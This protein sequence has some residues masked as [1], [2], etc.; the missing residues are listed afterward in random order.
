[1]PSSLSDVGRARRYMYVILLF[2]ILLAYEFVMNLDKGDVEHE[3]LWKHKDAQT[4]QGL[5][6]GSVLVVGIYFMSLLECAR[7]L[8]N[9]VGLRRGKSPHSTGGRDRPAEYPRRGRGVAATRLRRNSHVA[10]SPRL[11]VAGYPRLGV[12]ATRLRGISTSRCR[13]GSS[14]RNIRVAESASQ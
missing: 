11:A 8:L 5:Y 1:M 3:I 12:A 7:V 13:R 9:P 2:P 14:P 6:V 10:A 4:F